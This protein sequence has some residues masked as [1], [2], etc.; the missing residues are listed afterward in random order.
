MRPGAEAEVDRAARVGDPDLRLPDGR[1]L[2]AGAVLLHPDGRVLMQLRDD[3]PGIESPGMWSLFGG[4]L[5]VGET[6]E[7]GMAREV[8][9]ETG[10]RVRHHRPLLV[11]DGWRARYHIFLA[12]IDAPLG[13]LTLGEG[14]GFD[15]WDVDE[16]LEETRVTDIARLSLTAL[17]SLRRQRAQGGASGAEGGREAEL[18]LGAGY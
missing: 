11:L 10:Y 2:V 18:I 12:A 1:R 16:L 4:G 5:D 9:E 14:A 15:Y 7:Q 17:A 3:K 6:P 8:I 13:E